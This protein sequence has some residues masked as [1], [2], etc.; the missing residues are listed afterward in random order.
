M[1]ATAPVP[2]KPYH[3]GELQPA[4]LRVIGEL[5]RE[6]GIE[7]LSMRECARRAGVS[8]SAPIHHFGDKTG[9]L[10]AFA[11]EGFQGLRAA[12]EETRL[13]EPDPVRRSAQVG[14]AYLEFALSHPEHFRVMFRTELLAGDSPAYQDACRAAYQVLEDSF[15]ECDA[16]LGKPDVPNLAGRCLLAW[17]TVHGYATLCLEGAIAHPPEERLAVGRDLMLLLGPSLFGVGRG[18]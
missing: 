3:H 6:K 9:L 18:S 16:A 8:W 12:M 17:S 15:R 7:G 10:T 1:P 2:P 5:I 4:L 11:V 14:A 13:A